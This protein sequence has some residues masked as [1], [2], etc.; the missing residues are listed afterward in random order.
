MKKYICSIC[1]Y[2][3][4]G[5]ALPQKCPYCGVP[6]SHF[7]LLTEEA[8]KNLALKEKQKKEMVDVVEDSIAK[9]GYKPQ[10]YSR[11]SLF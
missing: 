10:G 11:N 6:A 3:H 4:E 8:M 1:D 5:E 7:K 9:A 2:V